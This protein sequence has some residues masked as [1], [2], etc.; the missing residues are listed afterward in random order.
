MRS[1]TEVPTSMYLAFDALFVVLFGV[2]AGPPAAALVAIHQRLGLTPVVQALLFPLGVLLYLVGLCAMAWLVRSLLPKLEAG[3]YA[4]PKD[5]GV[6]VWL[7]HFALMRVMY[8]PVW[9]PLMFSTTTL[10]TL[11]LRAL[12]ARVAFG[13]QSSSDPVLLDPSLIA[14][15][16]N[17]QISAGVVIACH[18]AMGRTLTLAPV[19]IGRGA[20]LLESVKVGPGVLVGDDTIVGAECLVGPGCIIG[21]AARLG[22]GCWLHSDVRI[23]DAA[24]IG[25]GVT[26]DRG[27]VIGARAKV[28]S[29]ATLDVGTVVPAGGSYP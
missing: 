7:L 18:A 1:A 11:V 21:G 10:R 28:A 6:I 24:R 14:V 12:G 5:R 16:R 23:G 29:G 27:V 3:I 20:Q 22:P 9:R 8:L 17:A 4:A 19:H 15:E 2:V 25:H 13:F 26:I